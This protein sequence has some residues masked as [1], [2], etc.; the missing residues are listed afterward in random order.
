MRRLFLIDIP[1][2]QGFIRSDRQVSIAMIEMKKADWEEME[3]WE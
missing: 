1:N 2:S 3:E